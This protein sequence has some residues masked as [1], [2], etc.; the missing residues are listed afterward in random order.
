M[1]SLPFIRYQVLM[2]SHVKSS[3]QINLG[4]TVPEIYWHSSPFAPFFNPAPAWTTE[5]NTSFIFLKMFVRW[6]SDLLN[7]LTIQQAQQEIDELFDE[8]TPEALG[9]PLTREEQ[10][11]LPLVPVDSCANDPGLNS[12]TRASRS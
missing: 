7:T 11:D 8:W 9:A 3:H 1:E 10:S 2:L 6:N 12:S 4:R 5:R